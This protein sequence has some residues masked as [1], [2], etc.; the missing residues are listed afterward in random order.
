MRRDVARS[1]DQ[2]ALFRST[3]Q[4]HS[5]KWVTSSCRM[6]R[7]SATPKHPPET[8]LRASASDDGATASSKFRRR[9]RRRYG[10]DARGPTPR[11]PESPGFA[12]TK[13]FGVCGLG[14]IFRDA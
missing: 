11:A 14:S 9:P 2:L 7:Q 13:D 5:E 6:Y 1:I 3:F 4:R 10:I 8:P 12:G